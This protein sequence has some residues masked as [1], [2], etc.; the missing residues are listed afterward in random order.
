MTISNQ[1]PVA[2]PG[3]PY[4]G[5]RLAAIAFNGSASGDPDDDALSYAWSFGDGGTGSGVAPTHLYATVGTFTVTLTVNDGTA[6]SAPVS[7]TVQVT[8]LAP[9][10]ALTS[11]AAGS[12]FNAPASVSVSAEASDSDG[13]V[14]K[15]EFYAGTL[16]IGEA[17]SAPTRSAGRALRRAPTR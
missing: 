8:N 9:S 16:K 14:S 3:G 5:T 7:T 10:V 15:V 6:D 17:L 13:A 1:A 12:V 4:S 11:P 2:N